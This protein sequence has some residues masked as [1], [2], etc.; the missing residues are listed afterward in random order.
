MRLIDGDGMRRTLHLIGVWI[1]RVLAGLLVLLVGLIILGLVM[2]QR[3]NVSFDRLT[4]MSH[5]AAIA[6]IRRNSHGSAGNPVLDGT[7][8]WALCVGIPPGKGSGE[9]PRFVNIGSTPMTIY[10]TRGDLG[11][12]LGKAQAY[13]LVNGQWKANCT[14]ENQRFQFH[15]LR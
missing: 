5:E 6:E 7:R 9:I 14:V 4:S 13:N 3:K 8:V 12:I 10:Q 1:A 11:F 2:N 15:R